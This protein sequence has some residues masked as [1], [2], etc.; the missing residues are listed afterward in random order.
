MMSWAITRSQHYYYLF[1]QKSS[2]ATLRWRWE[3]SGP[4]SFVSPF[5]IFQLKRWLPRRVFCYGAKGRQLHTKMSMYRT[6]TLGMKTQTLWESK[7]RTSN[8]RNNRILDFKFVWYSYSSVFR[9]LVPP[10]FM[11]WKQVRWIWNYVLSKIY[12][13]KATTVVIWILD[14]S[15]ISMIKNKTEAIWI[16]DLNVQ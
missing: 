1:L 10:W 15:S 12:N 16:L 9:C 13:L 14:V 2:M 3:W 5:K 6:S 7:Y 11:T 8:Y 4:S